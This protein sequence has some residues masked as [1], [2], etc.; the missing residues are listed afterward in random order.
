MISH[1]QL[2]KAAVCRPLAALLVGVALSLLLG[3][4]GGSSPPSTSAEPAP[5][6]EFNQADVDFAVQMSMHRSQAL[7]LA[8]LAAGRRT[9]ATTRTVVAR[10]RA[11]DG[12]AVDA[13]ATWINRWG[14]Q[15]AVLPPHG[16]GPSGRQPGIL[17]DTDLR[18]LENAPG[19]TFDRRF[20]AL[21]IIHHQSAITLLDREIRDGIS[22]PAQAMARDLQA[23][24]SKEI[25]A[26]RVREPAL[27]SAPP[28]RGR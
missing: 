28:G 27:V 17:A 1:M 5:A 21:M 3:A 26:M 13:I 24:Y 14:A 15:G 9:S 20:L 23:V 22:E 6:P 2:P 18:A 19:K 12:P 25:R 16:D 11:T 4:C 7:T 10:I 8:E